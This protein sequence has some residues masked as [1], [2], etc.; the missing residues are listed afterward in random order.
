MCVGGCEFE[1]KAGRRPACVLELPLEDRED[2][3]GGKCLW[4]ERQ[5]R[6]CGWLEKGASGTYNDV[7][8]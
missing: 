6:V 3:P 5:S 8:W 4:K 2:F 1:E 7:D